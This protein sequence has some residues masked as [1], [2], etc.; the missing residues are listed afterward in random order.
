M[1]HESSSSETGR[2]AERRRKAR[3]ILW[4]LAA[5]AVVILVALAL[6]HFLRDPSA[7]WSGDEE[8]GDSEG[9]SEENPCAHGSSPG[10]GTD[11]PWRAGRPLPPSV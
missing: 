8:G 7:A 1:T 5:I 4:R 3:P 9:N 2:P 6:A 10:W 11:A